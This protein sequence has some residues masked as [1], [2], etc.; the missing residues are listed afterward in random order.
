MVECEKHK[1]IE[2]RIRTVEA[3]ENR[4]NERINY[5]IEEQ[6]EMK[7]QIDKQSEYLRLLNENQ[8]KIVMKIVGAVVPIMSVVI[9]VLLAI[10]KHL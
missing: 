1:D 8:S 5:I 3:S 2:L 10:F 4:N 7:D 9:T 6:K